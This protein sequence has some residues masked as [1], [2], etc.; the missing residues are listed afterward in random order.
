MLIYRK[1]FFY[2]LLAEQPG[3]ACGK[4]FEKKIILKKII[5]EFFLVYNTT[6]PPMS[7]HTKFQPNRSSRLAGYTQ[8][9]HIGIYEYLGLTNSFNKNIYNKPN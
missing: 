9:R 4:N 3:V 7:V 5:F 8:H 2:K 6:R 1:E